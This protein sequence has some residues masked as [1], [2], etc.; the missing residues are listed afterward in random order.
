MFS[1]FLHLNI[2]NRFSIH[3][4]PLIQIALR[5]FMYT[6]YCL[7]LPNQQYI[8]LSDLYKQAMKKLLTGMLFTVLSVSAMAQTAKAATPRK[9]PSSIELY[10]IFYEF[11]NIE[12][13]PAEQQ[14]LASQFNVYNFEQF[15]KQSEDVEIYLSGLDKTLILYSVSK[16]QQIKLD[17]HVEF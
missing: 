2:Q 1:Y 5:I 8:R 9:Q 16:V 14:Q 4:N 7:K 3:F 12:L 13:S 10:K 11:K 6:E 17:Q 15:R